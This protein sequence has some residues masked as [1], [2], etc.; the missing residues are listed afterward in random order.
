MMIR[1]RRSSA[2]FT[3]LEVIIAFALLAL[4]LT[5]LLG[6]LSGASRQIRWADDASGAALHAQSLLA[7]VGVGEALEPGRSEGEFG[8]SEYR[9][10]L[11]VAPYQDPARP[12]RNLQPQQQRLLQLDLVVRWGDTP[13]DQLRWQTLRLVP[14]DLDQPALMP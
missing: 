5:L 7:Q 14:T 3:L 12:P 2:G 10:T 4:A 8:G 13:R 9:W 1:A 6:S 11:D